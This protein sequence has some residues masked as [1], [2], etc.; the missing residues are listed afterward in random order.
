MNLLIRA[1]ASVAMGTGHV[2]RCLALA[3][4]WQD[5]GGKPTF[6]I[7]ER[8]PALEARLQAERMEIVP[9][10]VESGFPDSAARLVQLARARGAEWIA[11]DGQQFSESYEDALKSSG[12]KLLVID[13]GGLN[14]P[15]SADFILNQNCEAAENLYPKRGPRTQLLLGSPYILLRKEFLEWRDWKQ[16]VEP[17]AKRLLV[18]MGGSDPDNLTGLAIQCLRLVKTKELEVEIV[19]GNSNPHLDQ[20]QTEVATLDLD[21]RLATNI[22]DMPG[23]MARADFALIAAGGTLWELLFMGCPTMSFGRDAVQRSILDCLERRGIVCH[24][25]GAER[26]HPALAAAAIDDLAASDEQRARMAMRGRELVDGEG[27]RRVCEM[28][29]TPEMGSA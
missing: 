2:M 8:V 28:L 18:T 25:T 22:L 5:K 24:V 11:L 29:L 19:V 23:R 21:V 26:I 14:R 27:G 13:D 3:Q 20:L 10:D 17:K 4:A 16:K 7:G 6:A 12:L 1:D 15:C 9:L